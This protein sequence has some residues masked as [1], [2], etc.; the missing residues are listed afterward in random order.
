VLAS[1][2]FGSAQPLSCLRHSKHKAVCECV[3]VC[4]C[5]CVCVC[6]SFENPQHWG[7][8]KEVAPPPLDK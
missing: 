5:V 8:S 7:S 2:K 6:L 1:G 4:V 3:R